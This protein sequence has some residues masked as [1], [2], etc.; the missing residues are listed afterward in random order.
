[1]LGALTDRFGFATTFTTM[2]MSYL[3]AGGIL[4]FVPRRRPA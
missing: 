1:V 3:V 4:L 2:A